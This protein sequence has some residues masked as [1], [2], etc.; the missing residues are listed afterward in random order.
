MPEIQESL[1][2]SAPPAKVWAFLM[3]LKSWPEW[4]TFVTSIEIQPP[5][6]EL[7]VGSKQTIIINKSQSYTNTVSVLIPEKELRWNGSILTPAFID[8][9]HWCLLERVDGDDTLT[10]FV[11]GERFSGML[12][13]IVG[14]MGKLE[15]LREGYVRMNQDLKK[16]IEGE[17]I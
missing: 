16:A 3:D 1:I 14:A 6:S 13:P 5:H 4:N 8:T 12:A 7:S 2:I 10:R 17:T 11:Q 15:E 9:E